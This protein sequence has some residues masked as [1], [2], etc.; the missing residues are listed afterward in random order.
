MLGHFRRVAL[1]ALAEVAFLAKT[2][3]F[4]GKRSMRM[5]SRPVC[6][7]I[8]TL[9]ATLALPA[10]AQDQ[11]ADPPSATTPAPQPTSGSDRMFLNFFEEATIVDGQWWEGQLELV[12][13]SD[14]DSFILRGVAAFQLRPK[15]EVGG[16]VGFGTTDSNVVPDGTGA[17]DLDLYGKWYFGSPGKKKKN[18]FAAG[19]ILTVPTGDNTSGLGQDAFRLGGFGSFRRRAKRIIWNGNLGFRINDDAEFSGSDSLDG[20]GST[21]AGFGILFPRSDKVSLIAE[22]KYE[23]KQFQGGKNLFSVLGGINWRLANQGMFRGAVDIGLKDGSPDLRV[24]A[25]Y[26][27]TF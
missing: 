3:V 18:E 27:R 15:L 22:T 14:I 7:V 13:D 20:K 21:W 12:N 10:S 16:T 24:L 9:T 17:T 5:L 26:A 2:P 19:A 6:L 25:G 4:K 23:S 11:P 8:L 1:A